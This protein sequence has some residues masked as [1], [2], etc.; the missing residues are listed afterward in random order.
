MS[1]WVDISS[2]EFGFTYLDSANTGPAVR[3]TVISA[4]Y[5]NESVTPTEVEIRFKANIPSGTTKTW[6]TDVLY[7]LYDANNTHDRRS[8][9]EFKYNSTDK[10]YYAE[11][12]DTPIFLNKNAT[13][14]TFFLQDV[15]ICNAGQGDVDI[16]ENSQTVTY[17][18]GIYYFHEVFADD[19]LRAHYAYRQS[20]G[21]SVTIEPGKTVVTN[22]TAP[23]INSFTDNGNNTVNITGNVGTRGANNPL[24]SATMYY[25]TNTDDPSKGSSDR[26]T[27][28]LSS[29][30]N[31]GYNKDIDVPKD[32]TTVRVYI[33]CRFTYNTTHVSGTCEGIKYYTAPGAPGIPEIEYK[34]SKPTNRESWTVTWTAGTK[35]NENSLIEGY[36][37]RIY[38][39]AAGKTSF[40]TV[41]V[42][43]A[44]GTILVGDLGEGRADRYYYDTESTTTKQTIYT[45]KQGFVPGDVIKVGLFS[46]TRNGA[47][48][49]LF[50]ATQVISE[51][52]TVQNAGIVRVKVDNEWKEGQVYVKANDGWHEAETVK[53]KTSSGWM[54]SQ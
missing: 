18:S 30:S 53:V 17:A 28:S 51:E 5:N 47:E 35:G 2:S 21:Q 38:K 10:C 12:R 14:S 27:I 44:N 20:A 54:E 23:K 42:C 34:K 8:V 1:N 45:G 46:Y 15:W 40:E 39:K 22:G 25:T 6:G 48:G 24:R 4:Q 50:N 32:C 49:Q 19:G 41:P 9:Y 7:V 33:E 13:S 26:K 43:D 36:R 11:G 3:K 52:L 31:G 37:F 29:T 16:D